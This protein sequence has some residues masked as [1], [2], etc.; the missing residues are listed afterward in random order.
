MIDSPKLWRERGKGDLAAAISALDTDAAHSGYYE[1]TRAFAAFSEENAD[2]Y[3]K[4]P[5][6]PGQ[7]QAPPPPAS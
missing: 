6:L 3:E 4:L 1:R 5:A 2:W 7:A